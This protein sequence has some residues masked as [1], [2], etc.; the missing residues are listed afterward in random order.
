ML[1]ACVALTKILLR[2]LWT[3]GKTRASLIESRCE[4]DG[5]LDV[6]RAEMSVLPRAGTTA[7]RSAIDHDTRTSNKA[8]RLHTIHD[9]RYQEGPT[10]S[11]I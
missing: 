10:S 2:T 4:R 9:L 11:S 5:T 3:D 6:D 1:V 8:V 7:Q